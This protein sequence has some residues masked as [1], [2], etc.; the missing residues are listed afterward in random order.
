MYQLLE[1]HANPDQAQSETA[2]ESIL[3][4]IANTMPAQPTLEQLVTIFELLTWSRNL[5]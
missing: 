3:A 1:G 5:V 2:T 4:A